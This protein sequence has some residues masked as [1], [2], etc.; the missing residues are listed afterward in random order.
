MVL[1][2]VSHYLRYHSTLA[3]QET[4]WNE[5]AFQYPEPGLAAQGKNGAANCWF[6]WC[7]V[8]CKVFKQK[9]L[10][11]HRVLIAYLEIAVEIGLTMKTL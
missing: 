7:E 3:D 11:D 8:M 5:D 9:S 6:H 2:E 4:Y 1:L 10:R